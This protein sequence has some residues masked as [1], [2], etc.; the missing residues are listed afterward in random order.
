MSGL[1]DDGGTAVD[2]QLDRLAIAQIHQRVTGDAPLLLRAAGEMMNAAQRQHLRAIFAGRHVTDR[3]A[4]RANRRRFGAEIAVGVDLHLDAAI[5]ED[6]LGHD[7]DHIDAVDFRRHDERRGLVVGIGGAGADRGHEDVRLVDDLAVPVA[8]GLE[9]HQPSALRYCPLQ[10]DM[11]IDPHQPA[12]V[13]G[14]A[15]AGP[16]RA[17][18][19]VTHHRASIAADLV[20]SSSRFSQHQQALRPASNCRTAR[21]VTTLSQ[22]LLGRSRSYR[23]SSARASCSYTNDVARAAKHC[24]A[25]LRSEKPAAE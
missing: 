5:T 6:A 15:V 18:L 24:Q 19:D 12:V 7:G 23:V 10:K 8:G 4:L 14:V 21:L 16:C 20:V 17:R 9:R 13:I 2:R 3:L 25:S 11:R 22:T 1:H